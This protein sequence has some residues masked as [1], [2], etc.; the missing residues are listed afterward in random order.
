MYA[1][2][3]YNALHTAVLRSLSHASM[4]LGSTMCLSAVYHAQYTST[5]MILPRYD[6]YMTSDHVLRREVLILHNVHTFNLTTT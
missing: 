5:T 3:M 4:L 6:I 2:A 1:C